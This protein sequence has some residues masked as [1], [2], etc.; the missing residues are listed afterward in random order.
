MRLLAR[1]RCLINLTLELCYGLT[2]DGLA[3][4]VHERKYLKRLCK[5]L[6][7]QFTTLM[8]AQASRSGWSV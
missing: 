1:S 6:P 4:F 8:I 3:E 7:K 5:V 2:D